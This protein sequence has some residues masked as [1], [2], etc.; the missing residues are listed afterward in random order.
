VLTKSDFKTA[1]ECAA[2]L[3][4]KRRHYPSARDDDPYLEFL[5]DGGYMVEHMAKLLYPDGRELPRRDDPL[6]AARETREAL[7]DGDVTLFEATVV[8][9]DL[10]ARIDILRRAGDVLHLVEVKSSAIDHA[11]ASP[12]RGRHGAIVA[13]WLPYLEDVT[14][15]AHVLRSAFPQYRVVPYLC[16]VDKSRVATAD[17]VLDRFELDRATR[18]VGYHGDAARLRDAH[19][20]AIVDVSAEVAELEPGVAAAASRFAASL[21]VV[22]PVRLT[23][24]IGQR[25]KSCEYRV[26]ATPSGFRECWGALADAD[27]HV[28]D[29]YRVDLLGGRRRDVVAELALAGRARLADVPVDLPS[30]APGVRQALQIECSAADREHIAPGL[31]ARL[32]DHDYPLHFIDFE[33]SR[34]AIPY[35]AGMRPYELAAFQWSCH[36][37]D[38]PGAAATHAEWLNTDDAFPNFA[39]ARAL[40][41]QVGERGTVYV[42][43]SYE[44]VVLNEIR[45]QLARYGPPDPGLDAWLADLA[46]DDNPRVVD[47]LKLAADGYFHPSMKGRLSIKYVLPAVWRNPRVRAHA[48]LRD[49]AGSDDPYAAL[50]SLPIAGAAESVKE[51]TGAMRVYQELMFGRGRGDAVARDACRRLLLRYCRLDTAAMLAIWLHWSGT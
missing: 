8:H 23:A 9:D 43:S 20:L 45:E 22:P 15:Q 41:A 31:P 28:L 10:S 4:Y 17:S 42:W 34:L 18:R 24:P 46:D 27:P 25:C 5:A 40:R 35:H 26:D 32:A 14:F 21:R 33:A 48:A 29:L 3:H 36:R 38:A 1:R 7:A 51:G 49:Y 16:V 44:R 2:K 6:Q 47:L 13:D 11:D 12:F 30:G 39:F 50:E 37:I 19:L